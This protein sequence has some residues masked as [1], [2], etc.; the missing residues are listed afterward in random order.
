MTSKVKPAVGPDRAPSNNQEFLEFTFGEGAWVWGCAFSPD[1]HGPNAKFKGRFS[2]LPAMPIKDNA[3][4][5]NTYY[6]VSRLK[7]KGGQRQRQESFFDGLMVLVIDDVGEKGRSL[8]EICRILPPT[9]VIHTS[10]KQVSERTVASYQVG[11]VFEEPVTDPETA[12]LLLKWIAAKEGDQS[13]N[14]LVRVVRL[15]FG[16]NT[17]GSEP[18]AGQPRRQPNQVR[19]HDWSGEKY[20]AD[21]LIGAYGIK[22]L[23]ENV[24]P[25]SVTAL[26][27]KASNG[28]G[29]GRGNEEVGD[30]DVYRQLSLEEIEEALSFID[31]GELPYDGSDPDHEEGKPHWLGILMAI[32]SQHPGADGK[33]L[34]DEWSK[35]GGAKYVSGEVD[36]RWGGFGNK[37]G[38]TIATLIKFARDVGWKP[39]K[40]LTERDQLLAEWGENYA[41]VQV[42]NKV[43]IL[44]EDTSGRHTPEQAPY[45]LLSFEDFKKWTATQ[46]FLDPHDQKHKRYADAW[47]NWPHRR[48]YQGIGC[49]PP[50]AGS[51]PSGYYNSWRGFAVEPKPGDCSLWHQHARDVYCDG[52][53]DHYQWVLKWLAALVQQPG[54]PVGTA[55]ACRGE[56]GT[57]KNAFWY[58]FVR[59]FG[60]HCVQFT[61]Q[62][63]MESQF[64]GLLEGKV[65]VL[66]NEAYWGG[67]SKAAGK[68][69]GLIT[70]PYVVSERKGIEAC[71]VFNPLWFGFLS[72]SEYFIPADKSSRRFMANEISDRHKQDPTYFKPLWDQMESGGTE[73]LLH[74]LLSVELS[75]DDLR[76]TLKNPLVTRALLKQGN[77]SH[78]DFAAWVQQLV[79]EGEVPY[80]VG[81]GD[82]YFHYP[83][84]QAF[85]HFS[86]LRKAAGLYPAT[87]GHAAFGKLLRAL[88]VTQAKPRLHGRQVRC[89]K[90]PP[91][92]ELRRAVA[93]TY[94]C[95]ELDELGQG[96][97]WREAGEGHHDEF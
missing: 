17:S 48:Q 56:E 81:D 63:H 71:T 55:L 9:Y 12:N 24:A 89:Y 53:E 20:K 57:G 70:E 54:K 42:G 37:P 78:E 61:D 97:E 15:P 59:I 93:Q 67:N 11:Y 30:A 79:L 91:L 32:H 50:G 21:E 10:D 77:R 94:P 87:V 19:L 95:D 5:C 7:E 44:L 85:E 90:L 43:R 23:P 47:F 16:M 38:F 58:P 76:S 6:C 62:Q 34:A 45:T 31:P 25:L 39:S 13:G 14:N 18:S 74:E 86:R 3:H 29:P 68:L 75:D 83:S 80:I 52:N 26:G 92:A 33:A 51:P 36:K 69:K 49:Y 96:G 2:K 46:T 40:G 84:K 4:L 72:N 73:A 88:G 28:G 35:R 1:P 82:R 8:E 66:N 64:T 22:P 65:L 27:R 41:V 60:S